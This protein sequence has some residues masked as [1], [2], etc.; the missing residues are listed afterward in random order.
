MAC[1][2]NEIRS[3]YPQISKLR[4]L[5]GSPC[6]S[7]GILHRGRIT[8]T[9]HF[10]QV[11]IEKSLPPNDD[12]IFHVASLTKVIAAAAVAYLVDEGV[13][14]WD[15]PV[16]HYLP[17]FKERQD[18]LGRECTLIDLLSNRSGIGMA[19]AL[20]GQKH[21]EF[22]LD[23]GKIVQTA[24]HIEA[25][26]PFRSSF[27]YSQWNY[28]LVTAIIESVTNETFGT[29]VGKKF[30]VPLGMSRTTFMRPV[31]D[32]I[33]TP[34]AIDN[35]MKPVRVRHLNMTDDTGFAGGYAA[36][37]TVKDLLILY[38]SLLLALAHESRYEG[39]PTNDTPFRN[40]KRIFSP[41]IGV[42]KA[43]MED[44]AY[45]LR[46]YRTPLPNSLSTSSV[47]SLLLGSHQ[48]PRIGMNST[49]LEVFHHA[50][51]VPGYFS[52]AF[53][54]PST[55]TAVVVLTNALSFVDPTDLMGQLPISQILDEQQL[56]DLYKLCHL[57]RSASM[58][59]YR[60]LNLQLEQHKPGKPPDFP[61]DGYEGQYCNSAGTFIIEIA[62]SGQ[63]LKMKMQGMPL[64][65]YHLI[66][67][68][69]NTFYW[70]ANRNVEIEKSMWPIPSPSYHKIV[71]EGN[72]THEIDRLKWK[73]D[74][75]ASPEVFRKRQITGKA[76]V[77]K[78]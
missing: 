15:L 75:N 19:N 20:W 7:L 62:Q 23:K 48:M 29:Y 13:L 72:K 37:T 47:N 50:G 40:V 52:S 77:G 16:R 25:V 34:H 2:Y 1:Y 26:M 45:C 3:L 18:D 28:A 14:E 8:H 11:G 39:R 65:W 21:G 64:T 73:H 60:A 61:P 41:C 27:V 33:A 67:Y 43:T 59:S 58:A 31:G 36:R 6:L 49:G 42:G 30:L 24:C 63:G 53:L 12:T 22:L 10:G 68:N 4:E 70:P 71:F 56:P 76:L 74:P 5:S 17:E 35:D 9:A 32:K 57:A 46:F 51:N 54:I 55:M 38:Q 69:G 44:V 66:P 78:L